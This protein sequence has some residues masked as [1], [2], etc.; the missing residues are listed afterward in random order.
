[1][2]LTL[3]LAG[4]L[5]EAQIHEAIRQ[6]TAAKSS[7]LVSI[8]SGRMGLGYLC[9]LASTPFQRVAEAAYKAA[10]KYQ[11]LTPEQVDPAALEP[12]LT[13]Y[14]APRGSGHGATSVVAIVIMPK[15]AKSKADAI[16][17]LRSEPLPLEMSNAFGATTSAE[18]LMAHFPLESLQDGAEIR[19]VYAA[20]LDCSLKVKAKDWP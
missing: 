12:V 14:G 6:G 4:A 16:Q 11:A 3:L 13:V 8:S 1:M 19:I 17:P 5:S 10:R 7:P 15:G 2:L 20:G 9:G 18:G